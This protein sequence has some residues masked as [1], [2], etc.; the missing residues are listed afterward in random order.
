[1]E[2]LASILQSVKVNLVPL[3]YGAGIKGKLGGAM[4]AGLPSV[5]TTLGVEGMALKAEDD[6]VF[7]ADDLQ[8]FANYVVNLTADEALWSRSSQASLQFAELNFG[9]QKL[10]DNV[11][12]VFDHLGISLPEITD[13]IVII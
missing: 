10:Y 4:A 7:I 8:L 11:V 6:G 1:V 5:S 13:D 2:D 3:R 9:A 12:E